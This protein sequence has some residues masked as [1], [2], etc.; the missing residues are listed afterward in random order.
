MVSSQ[1]A[2]QVLCVM[3]Y[4]SLA[5]IISSNNKHSTH[6]W[7]YHQAQAGRV[8]QFEKVCLLTGTN[9]KVNLNNLREARAVVKAQRS[10]QRRAELQS[11]IPGA[12]SEDDDV[13]DID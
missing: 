10:K 5:G 7:W 13:L 8:R 9:H 3:L 11:Q 6:E 4:L 2:S 12:D 1:L